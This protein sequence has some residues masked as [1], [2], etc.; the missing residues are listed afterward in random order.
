LKSLENKVVLSW[1]IMENQS[2]FCTNPV[3]DR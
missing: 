2:D 1:K 3:Y